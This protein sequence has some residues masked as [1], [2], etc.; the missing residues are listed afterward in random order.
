MDVCIN[1][2]FFIYK[3][4]YLSLISRLILDNYSLLSIEAKEN[5][6]E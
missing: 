3:Y 1:I 5:Y 2:Y 6:C 4:L